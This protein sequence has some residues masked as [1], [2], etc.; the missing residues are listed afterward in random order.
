MRPACAPATGRMPPADATAAATGYSGTINPCTSSRRN[1]ERDAGE[2]PP[3]QLSGARGGSRRGGA[4]HAEPEGSPVSTRALR[5]LG[6]L[7]LLGVLTSVFLLT[8]GAA[9]SPSQYVPARSGGWPDWLAGPLRGPRTWASRMLPDAH[10]DHGRELPGGAARRAQR[11]R[12]RALAVT[13]VAAH[14]VLLLGPPLIS[15]DV[16]GYLDFARLGALH[17]LDPYT[18]VAA[19]APTRSGLPVRRLAL[20]ALSLRPAV[21]ARQ[22]RDRAARAR[23][24]AVGVEGDRGRLEPRRGGADRARGREAGPLARASPPPSWV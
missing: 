24:R 6:A 15:Q 13:I 1:N 7:G 5:A 18:H 16:F 8:A 21:H 4:A 10:A 14:L 19:Q 12:G 3:D 9:S 11:Y 2:H 17:G 20:P 23:R 22:L